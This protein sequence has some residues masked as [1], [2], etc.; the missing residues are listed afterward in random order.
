MLLPEI[1]QADHCLVT[2][3]RSLSLPECSTLSTKNPLSAVDDVLLIG[4]CTK[5]CATILY[6]PQTSQLTS[7]HP[8]SHSDSGDLCSRDQ[9]LRDL[10]VWIDLSTT[11]CAST[12]Y[13]SRW[14][15][16]TVVPLHAKSCSFVL[17]MD[18]MSIVDQHSVSLSSQLHL[19]NEPLLKGVLQGVPV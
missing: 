5:R 15:W 3:A 16:I 9:W 2:R 6:I 17:G 11:P 10:L 13:F 12:Q 18:D 4:N 14:Q 19:G 8:L 7:L 1:I